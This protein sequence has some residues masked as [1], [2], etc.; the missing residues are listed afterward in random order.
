[1]FQVTSVSKGLYGP[2]SYLL[3]FFSLNAVFKID[4]NILLLNC[5]I[6]YIYIHVISRFLLYSDVIFLD[7]VQINWG[8]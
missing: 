1:M 5:G 2:Q 3:L 8:I 6:H 4:I 7:T